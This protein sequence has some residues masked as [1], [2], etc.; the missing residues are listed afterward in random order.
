MRLPKGACRIS[1]YVVFS[2]KQNRAAR[3]QRS[4]LKAACEPPPFSRPSAIALLA[5]S[6][7]P[8]RAED[9][10]KYCEH[11]NIEPIDAGTLAHIT[12][13]VEP[14]RNLSQGSYPV[15]LICLMIDSTTST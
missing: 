14:I 12:W 3:Q 6:Q 9:I 7:Y 1:D 2:R 5:L 11:K 10:Q 13:V 15:R 8:N 4:S